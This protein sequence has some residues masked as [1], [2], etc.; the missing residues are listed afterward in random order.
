MNKTKSAPGP[1]WGEKVLGVPVPPF[2]VDDNFVVP[3]VAGF[4]YQDI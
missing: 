4:A 1:R 3:V 2:Q